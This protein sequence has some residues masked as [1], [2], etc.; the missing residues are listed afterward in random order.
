MAARIPAAGITYNTRAHPTTIIYSLPT[1]ITHAQHQL[2]R[3]PEQAHATHQAEGRCKKHTSLQG[4]MPQQH[5]SR[6]R[7]EVCSTTHQRPPWGGVCAAGRKGSR[8]ASSLRR[9]PQLQ[10]A[11]HM[12]CMYTGYDGAVQGRRQGWITPRPP[13][14]QSQGSCDQ[15]SGNNMLL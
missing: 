14:N 2:A 15:D 13:L 4:R 7:G 11:Q 8:L 6:G 12:R 5:T 3:T 1:Q 9:Q 10:D